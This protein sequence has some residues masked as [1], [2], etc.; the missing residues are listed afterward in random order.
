MSKQVIMLT[1]D[2][3]YLTDSHHAIS[4][5]TRYLDDLAGLSTS[6]Y[7][8][9][10]YHYTM[11]DALDYK[12]HLLSIRVPGGTVGYIEYDED[13]R[14]QHIHVDTEY[15][16]KTYPK[17]INQLISNKF[18]GCKLERTYEITRRSE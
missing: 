15:V 9:V 16:V 5:I 13:M 12:E 1:E 14:I 10:F 6:S 17:D 3:N 8:D 18:N 11:E 2:R 7:Y 4:E